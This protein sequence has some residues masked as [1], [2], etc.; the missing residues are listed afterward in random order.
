MS[1]ATGS[2]GSPAPSEWRVAVSSALRSRGWKGEG[3]E[4]MGRCLDPKHKD[5]NPSATWSTANGC[6][7]CHGCGARWSTREAGALLGLD[8]NSTS[9]ASWA[10][11][12]IFRTMKGK[13]LSRVWTYRDAEGRELGCVARYDGDGG[14]TFRPFFQREGGEWRAGAA[15]RPRPLYRLDALAARPEAP[16]LVAEGEK[17][18]DAAQQLLP[19]FVATAWPGGAGG[20]DAADWSSL[21]GRT[22]AVWPD[23]DAPGEVA[24]GAVVDQLRRLGCD[25]AMVDVARLALPDGGDAADLD[26]LPDGELPLVEPPAVKAGAAPAGSWSPVDLGPILAGDDA[27]CDQPSVLE[28]E[29]GQF[30]LYEAAI[31]AVSA[32]PEAGKSWLAMLAG[33]QVLAAGG[34]VVYI[35]HEDAPRPVVARLRAIGIDDRSI[36]ERFHYIRPDE[37]IKPADLDAIAALNPRLIVVDGVNEAM[38]LEGLDLERNKQVADYFNRV[39]KPLAVRTGAAVLLLDHVVKNAENRGRY[40]IGGQAK[41]AGVQGA[42]Y[43]LKI[44]AP[45]GRGRVGSS[46]LHLTKDRRG[47]IPTQGANRLVGTFTITA[48]DDGGR[49]ALRL[50]PA[51]TG[52]EFRPTGYMER[53]SRELE[54]SGSALSWNQIKL[55]V[56][57]NND[58][59]HLALDLLV[60]DGYVSREDGPRRSHLHTSVRPYRETGDLSQD[61]EG[62][63]DA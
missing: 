11:P 33:R 37:P 13:T 8:L 20:V 17:S 56:A 29:T 44:A 63:G 52:E 10:P 24:G 36:C 21:A 35:D 46:R 18:A 19:D 12:G 62:D 9:S 32:P 41:L 54:R 1:G 2:T 6:G 57:G 30:L 60:R 53:V 49:V 25:V 38:G 48:D 31:N 14:K 59:K 40:P 55:A 45:F 61:D 16:V 50:D 26:V 28:M 5:R 42:S 39:P 15:P 51:T 4:L 23:R 47:W 27:A 43:A 58:H 7:T 34:S 22:V 3:D